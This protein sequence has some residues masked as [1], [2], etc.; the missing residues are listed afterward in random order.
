MHLT[1]F[2]D[3][4]GQAHV[5]L[6]DSGLVYPLV[7]SGGLLT[8]CMKAIANKSG[9]ADIV[10]SV[11]T[12]PP[13]LYSTLLTSGRLLPPIP[14][15]DSTHTLIS[16]TGLTH[17][18]SVSMRQEMSQAG[19]SEAQKLYAEGVADG[20]PEA[21]KL[22][23]MP[24]WFFKGFGS[25]LRT[26]HQKLALPHYALDGGEEAELAVIYL[27]GNDACPYRLGVTLGNEFSDHLLEKKNHYYLARSKLRECAIGAELFVGELPKKIGGSIRI[28]RKGVDVW[29]KQY[30]TGAEKMI[31]SLDNI[32]RHFFKYDM[33]C[34]PGQVHVF[35]LGADTVSFKDGIRLETGDEITIDS[36]FFPSALVNTIEYKTQLSE[37]NVVQL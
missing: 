28:N 23:A 11:E 5:G 16:G 15:V 13:I 26:S 20:K 3:Q 18:N 29:N 30:E 10:S 22:G 27:I 31:Y 4:A 1:Q 14:L 12:A 17:R 34:V 6:V 2:S 9:L 8:L 7:Y 35:F 21:D 19:M 37:C 24:E 32:E 33:F 25:Q 36:D